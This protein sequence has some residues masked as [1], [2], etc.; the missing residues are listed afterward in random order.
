MGKKI[1][2]NETQF[3]SILNILSENANIKNVLQNLTPNQF[4]KII[5]AKGQE[6]IF[7]IV[8]YDNDVFFA[9]DE[10]GFKKIKFKKDSFNDS[11]SELNVKSLN[12]NT[13][14]FVDTKIGVKD[15]VLHDVGEEE[16]E[17]DEENSFDS[18]LHAKYYK[19][20]I[21]NPEVQKAFYTAPSLWNYFVAAIKN[22]KARGSGL[23]PAYKTISDIFNTSINNK[24]PGFTD[25]ENLSAYFL[26]PY[27]VEIGYRYDNGTEDKLIINAG[28]NRAVVRPYEPGFSNSKVL[29]RRTYGFKIVVK[30]PTEEKDDQYYCDIYVEK[31]GVKLDTYKE[32]N[33]KLI[34]LKSK[35]YEPQV[36][37]KNK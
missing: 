26:V 9:T 16:K 10:T 21:N 27:R 22:K 23:Y 19:D 12:P 35:G 15:I 32:E 31:K 25:K 14:T 3:N 6:T 18:E 24:L 11:T 37:T 28:N 2:I 34:F 7:K 20:V 4:I 36:K 5:D 1:K 13:N 33:I 29:V 17:E 30:K 8:S